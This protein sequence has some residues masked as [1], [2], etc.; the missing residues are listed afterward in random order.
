MLMKRLSGKIFSLFAMLALVP[1]I[2]FSMFFLSKETNTAADTKVSI[3]AID[4]VSDKNSYFTMKA[5]P[6]SRNGGTIIGSTQTVTTENGDRKFYCFNWETFHQSPS[7][8]LLIFL[9]QKAFSPIIN[10]S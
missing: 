9:V 7:I 3:S 5:T 8:S 10:F 6:V 2:F 1:A 4:D